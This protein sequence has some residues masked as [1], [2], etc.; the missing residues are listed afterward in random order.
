[1]DRHLAA[2]L[3]ADVAGMVLTGVI[4]WTAPNM[5]RF[6]MSI[7]GTGMIGNG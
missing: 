7:A 1:M 4:M 2:M 6:C 5:H 3:A